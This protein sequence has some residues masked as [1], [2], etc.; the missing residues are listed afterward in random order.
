MNKIGIHAQV[1][2]D[3][4]AEWSNKKIHNAVR[5]SKECGYDFIELPVSGFIEELQSNPEIFDVKHTRMCLEEFDL[6]ITTGIGLPPHAD[7]ANPNPD[8]AKRGER[9]LLKAVIFAQDLGANFLGGVTHGA[10]VRPNSRPDVGAMDR[11]SEALE[12]VARVAEDCGITLGVEVVNRYESSLVNTCKQGVELVQKINS[13]NVGIHADTYHM[14]IEE[15]DTFTAFQSCGSMLKYVHVGE[16]H[17]GL[18]GTGS[19][20]FCQVFRSLFSLNYRGPIAV[21]SFSTSVFPE[22]PASRLAVWRNMWNDPVAFASHARM[23]VEHHLV[24][25]S[26]T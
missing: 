19:V 25:A 3:G 6:G 21:E 13:R 5:L 11:V 1:W 9:L 20:D 10:L 24:S 22:G 4:T 15:S 8:I 14:N 26:H 18:L 12:K 17:R 7:I 2:L 16:S 23:F